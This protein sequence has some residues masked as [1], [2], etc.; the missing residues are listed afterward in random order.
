MRRWRPLLISAAAPFVT[1]LDF[2][3]DERLDLPQSAADLD[4]AASG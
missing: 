1:V 2:E 3:R 4:H